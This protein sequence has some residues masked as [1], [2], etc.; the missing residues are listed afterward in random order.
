MLKFK[1]KPDPKKPSVQQW[2]PIKD[3]KDGIVC[4]K[5][6][7]YIKAL[8]ITPVNFKLKSATEKKAILYNYKGFLKA[9]DFDIQIVIKTNRANVEP[10]IKRIEALLKQEKNEYVKNMTDGYI[11]L[12]KELAYKKKSISRRFFIIFEYEP[13]SNINMKDINFRDIVQSL[14]NKKSKIKEYL[15]K[16]GNDIIEYSETNSEMEKDFLYNLYYSFLN[17]SLSSVQP[18]TNNISHYTDILGVKDYDAFKEEA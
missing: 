2:I 15:K 12:V 5:N 4:L 8:E 1:N 9:C 3:I 18:I 10:H 11:K 7:K 17:K 14:N 13:P 16:C 6:G